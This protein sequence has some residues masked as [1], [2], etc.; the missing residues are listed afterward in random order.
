MVYALSLLLAYL[1]GSF[2]TGYL[3]VRLLKGIDVRTIGSRR[4]G[5]TNVIRAAGWGAGVFVFVSDMGKGAGAVC[6]G[7]W[8][9]GTPWPGAP[10]AGWDDWRA[11]LLGLGC[12]LAAIVGHNWPLY[13]GFRGGRGVAATLGSALAMAPFVA[14]GA[15]VVALAVVAYW[16]YVSLGSIIGC[17]VLTLGLLIQAALTDLPYWT[18]LYGLVVGVLVILRHKDNIERLRAGT[19]R[20]LG[21]RVNR[22]R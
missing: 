22:P 8:L 3:L 5:A 18:A 6:L 17:N 11:L 14:V 1:I 20:K 9:A 19:E 2:P 10:Q 12:G 4:T 16:R 13:L 15:F 7:R 21:D